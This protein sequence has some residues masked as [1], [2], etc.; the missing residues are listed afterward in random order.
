MKQAEDRDAT[1][2]R[3]CSPEVAQ[4]SRK[5]SYNDSRSATL[6]R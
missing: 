3:R 2:M 5:G 1:A 4:Q 6:Y